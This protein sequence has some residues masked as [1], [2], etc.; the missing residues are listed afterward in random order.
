MNDKIKEDVYQ[1]NPDYNACSYNLCFAQSR[2]DISPH[3]RSH[4]YRIRG[5]SHS[6]SKL[7]SRGYTYFRGVRKIFKCIHFNYSS[8]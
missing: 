7:R 5:H 3:L 1:C 6:G 8:G 4:V 2:S